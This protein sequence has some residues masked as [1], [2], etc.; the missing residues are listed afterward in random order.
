MSE[1]LNRIK[2][3]AMGRIYQFALDPRLLPSYKPGKEA[4]I[5]YSYYSEY[6]SNSVSLCLRHLMLGPLSS[7]ATIC[8]RTEVLES[9]HSAIF[10]A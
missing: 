7:I 10:S 6:H 1:L 5:I 3:A 9:R 2:S 8:R 4:D